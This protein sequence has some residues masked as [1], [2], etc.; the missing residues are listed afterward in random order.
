MDII[1]KIMSWFGGKV[2]PLDEVK[3][4]MPNHEPEE[5]EVVERYVRKVY[6]DGRGGM[7]E[8]VEKVNPKEITTTDE[9]L[10]KI[11]QEKAKPKKPRKPKAKKKQPDSPK[12]NQPKKP[13]KPRKPKNNNN[14]QKGSNK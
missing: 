10:E 3:K 13:R 5:K 7:T 14:Q 11:V 8:V 9:T 1:E 4:Q 12:T 6:S 2:T